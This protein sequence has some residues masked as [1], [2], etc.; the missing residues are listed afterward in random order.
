MKPAP[1]PAGCGLNPQLALPP[2]A[3]VGHRDPPSIYAE[4]SH[5]PSCT[6]GSPGRARGRVEP[7]ILDQAWPLARCGPA[8]PLAAPLIPASPVPRA[9][10]RPGTWL[11]GVSGALVPAAAVRPPVGS[12]RSDQSAGKA[13][14]SRCA[15]P[16]ASLRLWV[17]GRS[18]GQTP[19]APRVPSGRLL[20][21]PEAFWPGRHLPFQLELPPPTP[22]RSD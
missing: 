10:P 7:G 12:L 18:R 15:P 20:S 19:F 1:S 4:L 8:L 11:R 2:C 6:H 14:R 13:E 17:A 22:P 16:A 9:A 5:V 3:G 21:A